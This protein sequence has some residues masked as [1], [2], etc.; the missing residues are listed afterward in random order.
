MVDNQWLV[1]FGLGLSSMIPRILP[2]FLLKD[3]DLSPKLVQW[4][5]YIPV[6]IFS[7]LVFSDIFFWEERFVLSPIE[8]LKLLP[9]L[10]VIFISIKVNNL[11]ISMLAGVVAIAL[12][13]WGFS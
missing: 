6:T 11:F 2:L 5:A 13:V 10:F 8:N 12:M 7:A 4:M 3:K 9:S 1:V